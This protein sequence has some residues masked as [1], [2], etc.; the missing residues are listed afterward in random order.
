MRERTCRVAE[1]LLEPRNAVALVLVLVLAAGALGSVLERSVPGTRGVTPGAVNRTGVVVAQALGGIRNAAAAYIWIKLDEAHH[2]FYGGTFSREAPLA[3]W[4]RIAAW[5][6]PR[7]EQA[8]AVGSYIVFKQGRPREA[9]AFAREGLAS[10]PDSLLLTLNL[11]Q[12][13]LFQQGNVAK[14]GALKYLSRAEEMSR[15]TGPSVRLQVLGSLNAV[16][17]KWRIPNE[18]PVVSRELERLRKWAA[19]QPRKPESETEE[20]EP[21]LL[22]PN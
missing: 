4:Y 6:D 5:L 19:K 1:R 20:P 22:G 12:L 10:N 21:D 14:R 18:P 8:F 15:G 9:L 11:G 17:T 2:E 13:Y 3:P 16:Y 7:M